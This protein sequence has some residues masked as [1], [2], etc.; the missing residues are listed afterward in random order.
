[1]K[2]I[3][4]IGILVF[5]LFI[6]G[7]ASACNS[8]YCNNN[9]YSLDL[10]KSANP[11]TYDHV[12]QVIEYTYTVTNKGSAITG[13]ITITDNKIPGMIRID[14]DLEKN[15]QVTRKANYVITPDDLDRGYVTNTATATTI[16]SGKT[17]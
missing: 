12:G 10:V 6:V 13:T 2:L 14:D 7:S 15:A 5:L 3:R 1:M 9:Y 11:A 8:G 4:I 17:I 16:V